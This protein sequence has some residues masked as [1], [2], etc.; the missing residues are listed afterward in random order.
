MAGLEGPVERRIHGALE[1]HAERVLLPQ[2]PFV[3]LV[4][5]FLGTSLMAEAHGEPALDA[6]QFGNGVGEPPL[7]RGVKV[8]P[9]KCNP[10]S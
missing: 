9:S 1:L 5:A 6:A 8:G 7:V 10:F 4:F 3:G 2:E